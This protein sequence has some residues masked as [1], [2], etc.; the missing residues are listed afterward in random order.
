MKIDGQV[1]LKDNHMVSIADTNLI[2]NLIQKNKCFDHFELDTHGS[3]A[4]LHA[5][6]DEPDYPTLRIK[7]FGGPSSGQFFYFSPQETDCVTVGRK[8][9]DI[10]ISD[11]SMSKFQC[12]FL[13]NRNEG[14]WLIEDGF[15]NKT[16]TNGTFLF[17]HDEQPIYDGMLIKM[18]GSLFESK[19]ID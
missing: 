15:K 4:N 2:I 7:I 16:S 1:E 5:Q 3:K 6:E 13:F 17:L 18:N 12:T 11:E 19:L 14:I 8:N 9:T 10:I